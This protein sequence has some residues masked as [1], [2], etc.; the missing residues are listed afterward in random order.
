MAS[1]FFGE[2][3]I[4][5]YTAID[6]KP[7]LCEYVYHNKYNCRSMFGKVLDWLYKY[8]NFTYYLVQ[9]TEKFFFE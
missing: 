2:V 7:C 5:G 9:A 1:N 4:N 8:E 6:F 3:L